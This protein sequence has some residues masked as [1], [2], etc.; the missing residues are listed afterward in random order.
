MCKAGRCRDLFIEGYCT[1]QKCLAISST[2]DPLERRTS[3]LRLGIEVVNGAHVRHLA[4][5]LSSLLCPSMEIGW[6]TMNFAE[7]ANP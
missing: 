7:V 2:Y 6:I 3:H 1:M 5:R 4:W